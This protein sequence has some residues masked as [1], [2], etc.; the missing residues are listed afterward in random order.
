MF[1]YRSHL[2]GV[3]RSVLLSVLFLG[4]GVASVACGAAQ[5]GSKPPATASTAT[6]RSEP[7]QRTAASLGAAS[8]RATTATGEAP[9][10]G[11][12][13]YEV[14][15]ELVVSSELVSRCPGLQLVRDHAGEVDQDMLWITI[16]ASIA[17]CMS[18]GAPLQRQTIG[19]SG[20]ERHRHVV[21]EVL[22]ARGIAPTRVLA[23]PISA[24]GLAECQGGAE[25]CGRRVEITIASSL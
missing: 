17:N 19:V 20:D 10:R 4:G 21:R 1:I 9:Q 15:A 25:G 7:T 18:E 8:T 5:A 22:S 13:D 14:D 12:R 2:A 3:A 23:T 16:L 11:D 6:I 24:Q